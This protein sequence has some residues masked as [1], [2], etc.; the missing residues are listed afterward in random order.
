M[1]ESQPGSLNCTPP[2]ILLH[3][4]LRLQL[5]KHQR[6]HHLHQHLQN[7]HIRRPPWYVNSLPNSPKKWKK[8]LMGL[9]CRKCFHLIS[10]ID[11][12]RKNLWFMPKSTLKSRI[13][14]AVLKKN[15]QNL[16]D[17]RPV[18]QCLENRLS[19]MKVRILAGAGVVVSLD[20][21]SKKLCICSYFIP[22]PF[23]PRLFSFFL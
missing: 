12:M 6:L 13:L 4:F 23:I 17:G 21:F 5:S 10:W 2:P 9:E 7:V 18:L 1:T 19:R 8:N 16:T 15:T 11:K 20:L 22:P 14:L 3:H